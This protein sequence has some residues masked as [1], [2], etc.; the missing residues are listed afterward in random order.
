MDLNEQRTIYVTGKEKVV[1][2]MDIIKD[3]LILHPN[4][5]ELFLLRVAT[6]LY[7]YHDRWVCIPQKYSITPLQR[8]KLK[9]IL[10]VFGDREGVTF[11]ERWS[12]VDNC[13]E[14]TIY[15]TS[16]KYEHIRNLRIN[17]PIL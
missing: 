7:Q 6:I 2:L 17:F 14:M 5:E 8:T 12:D 9:K 13:Q 3:E 1:P 16:N 11:R 10:E 15:T 4:D